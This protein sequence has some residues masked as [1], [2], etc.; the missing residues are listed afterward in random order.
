[1]A[2]HKT[3]VRHVLKAQHAARCGVLTLNPRTWGSEAN[4]ALLEASLVYIISSRP[5]RAT[6]HKEINNKST[7]EEK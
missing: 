7:C 3:D 2:N 4:R 1:M 5:T 6:W